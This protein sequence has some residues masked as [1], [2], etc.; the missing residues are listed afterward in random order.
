MSA[1]AKSVPS[2]GLGGGIGMKW[3][4]ILDPNTT[5]MSPSNTRAMMARAFMRPML[6]NPAEISTAINAALAPRAHSGPQD[7]LCR[8]GQTLLKVSRARPRVMAG[9]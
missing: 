8:S 9:G 7:Q 1:L 5:N 4:K 3:K 2:D 6:I